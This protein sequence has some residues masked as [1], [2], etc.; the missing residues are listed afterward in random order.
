M[1]FLSL[2]KRNIIYKLKKKTNIDYLDL[3][4][5]TL[6]QLF[7]YFGS[8]K[9]K[10]SKLHNRPGHGFAK[11]Y[12]KHF[13]DYIN[14]DLSILEIGSY[15]GAS[16]AS[17]VKFLPKSKVFCL[18]VNIS[19]FKYS[20]KKIHV[21]GVDVK[22][23]DKVSEIIDAIYKKHSI[24]SFDIII[25]DGSHYLSDILSSLKYFMVH[26]SKGGTYVIEDFKHP[27]YYKYNND[28]NHIF[29]EEVLS[30]LTNNK[31]FTSKIFS[32]EDQ[33]VLANSIDKVDNYR[34]NLSDSDI[35]FIKKIL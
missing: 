25:D 17:F 7:N 34:G 20:S 9:A 4:D 29:V 6:D 18:D 24:R 30:K 26:L 1:N 5:F 21:Y 27:N 2:F 8:D 33:T 12:S 31:Q 23:T 32:S 10:F 14:K 11:I 22:N 19:N 13:K 35:S 15:A 28:I 16:A 3:S